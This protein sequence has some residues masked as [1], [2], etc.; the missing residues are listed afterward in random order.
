M[1]VLGTAPTPRSLTSVAIPADGGTPR[2]GRY[3][4]EIETT[5]GGSQPQ[6]CPAKSD[7]LCIGEMIQRTGTGLYFDRNDHAT[8]ADDQVDFS[9]TRT[10]VAADDGTASPNE[11]PRSYL[12]AEVA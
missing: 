9:T 2:I 8:V 3:G 4:D 11:K 5:R 12:L 6:H 1:L 7:N 10:N